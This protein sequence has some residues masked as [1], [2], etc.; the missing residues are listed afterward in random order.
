MAEARHL[1]GNLDRRAWGFP[2]CQQHEKLCREA[3]PQGQR[4]GARGPGSSQVRP[5]GPAPRVTPGR[6]LGACDSILP[7]QTWARGPRTLSLLSG[8]SRGPCP[9]PFRDLGGSQTLV[10]SGVGLRVRV[11]ELRSWA[12]GICVSE[13]GAFIRRLAKPVRTA[14]TSLSLFS[15]RLKEAV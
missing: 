11:F 10:L 7:R 2:F 5:V 13:N 4:A 15:F 1:L 6:D 14:A 9:S 12:T 8:G 3:S